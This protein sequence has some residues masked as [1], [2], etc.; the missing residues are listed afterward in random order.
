[1]KYLILIFFLTLCGGLSAQHIS[2]DKVLIEK[3]QLPSKYLV[4]EITA[5]QA[6]KRNAE[7]HQILKEEGLTAQANEEYLYTAF[8]YHFE[9]KTDS[10]QL[11]LQEGLGKVEHTNDTLSFKYL[12]QIAALY[13]R[14]YQLDS[15]QLYF[16]KGFNYLIQHPSIEKQMPNEVVS[17]NINF[18]DYL[19]RNGETKL[20]KDILDKTYEIA[21]ALNKTDYL[22]FVENQLALYYKRQND[23]ENQERMYLL[24]ISHT[25]K[26][27]YRLARYL[28][29]AQL[30]QDLA[31][32]DK[33]EEV[34]PKIAKDLSRIL[35]HSEDFNRLKL[36]HHFI[37]SKWLFHKNET[38][39][40]KKLLLSQLKLKN[41]LRTAIQSE[42]FFLLGENSIGAE[43]E[44]FIK[45]AIS[46]ALIDRNSDNLTVKNVLFP[47]QLIKALRFKITTQKESINQAEIRAALNLINQI[48]KAFPFEEIK[49]AYQKEV[50][51]FLSDL[52]AHSLDNPNNAFE[53]M[54]YGKA[55]VLNDVVSDLQIKFGN[56][57]SNLL[58][59]EK[60]V[61]QKLTQLRVK[62]ANI[63]SAPDSL[64]HA[65]DKLRIKQSFLQKE[66]EQ[67]SPNYYALKYDNNI[68][69][70]G[71]IQQ[72]LKSNTAILSYFKQNEKLHAV[73]VKKNDK[74]VLEIPLKSN[75]IQTL[76]LF[77]REITTNPGL[78]MYKLHGTAQELYTLLM[79][80]FE[81]DFKDIT[82]LIILR[83]AELNQ[84]P[85]EI[86]ENPEG[87]LL[88]EKFAISYN[89]SAA[90]MLN[91]GKTQ[92][93]SSLLAFAPYANGSFKK[94]NARERN[95]GQLPFS[96]KEVDRISGTIYKNETATKNHFLQDYQKH[97][98]I[99]FAT[100]AQM[101]DKDPSRSFIAFYPDSIDY[102]LYTEELYNLSLR[103][104][105][106]VIL[107]AC[108]AGGGKL[109]QGEGLMSLA[110]GFT[111]AGCPSVITTLWKANDQ[112][113]AWLSERLHH[114]LKK[115]W[116]KAR[117][118]QHAKIDFR[119]S[120]IGQEFDHPYYWANFI[121]I[122]NEEPLE[123]SFWELYKWW[124]FRSILISVIISLVLYRLKNYPRTTT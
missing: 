103:N 30:Y 27:F 20:W 115:G 11:F 72:N 119:K 56:V 108:E 5:K 19:N 77:L 80:D 17:F 15:A 32:W 50:R 2:I 75:F 47:E 9:N 23:V 95:L 16:K 94:I 41:Y 26:A 86:L 114:Y 65:V 124:I 3:K 35:E 12:A 64:V 54:E 13:D 18:M 24:S 79:G 122:G 117:A 68:P 101:D 49:Y 83:D 71:K 105:Q 81:E 39:T 104:T 22:G 123:L 100:H 91:H 107:S 109:Q 55:F 33:Y 67:K 97:G 92:K 10:A 34:F 31:K 46:S 8:I 4:R 62:L 70:I 28:K 51:P 37:Y 89:Y 58:Q 29:L 44:R 53:Y 6:L 93:R 38:K 61:D 14:K 112:S 52:I 85:F 25:S 76:N 69:T 59:E 45:S 36:K 73:L 21:K 42:A 87:H 118:L 82:E 74:K 111:Y 1:M 84:L 40:A 99:H 121:L 98:I 78:G 43:Q 60:Y 63:D 102:K 113:T 116:N 120:D 48:Q 110:R 88:L 57:D 7:I 96:T 106:L 66:M 90:L